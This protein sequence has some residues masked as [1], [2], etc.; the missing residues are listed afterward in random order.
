MADLT[1]RVSE[2]DGGPKARQE[3]DA[4]A[5]RSLQAAESATA[6]CAALELR[7]TEFQK[8]SREE[9]AAAESRQ[10]KTTRGAL[11]DLVKSLATQLEAAQAEALAGAVAGSSRGPEARAEL[12]ERA[13]REREEEDRARRELQ[14]LQLQQQQQ[15]QQRLEQ[16]QQQQRL[17]QQQ[18]AE[19]FSDPRPQQRGGNG[20]GGGVV[21][22]ALASRLEEL[23]SYC[24]ELSRENEELRAALHAAR[25]PHVPA[26][27]ADAWT[28]PFPREEE[29]RQRTVAASQRHSMPAPALNGARV[30]APYRFGAAPFTFTQRRDTKLAY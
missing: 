27:R 30:H 6:A 10:R 2:L 13:R 15:Q 29:A 11:R 20:H 25:R 16:Q 7:L 12:E 4:L 22:S 9:L 28:A 19:H 24:E 21:E 23:R 5:K 18:Q 17:E 1:R 14:L 8:A 3:N 26:T